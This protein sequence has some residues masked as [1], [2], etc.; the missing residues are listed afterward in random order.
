MP[1]I[2]LVTGGSSDIGCALIRRLLTNGR[3][4]SV[5]AH[6]HSGADRIANLHAQFGE[7]VYPVHADFSDGASVKA[8]ADEIASN[9]G[10]PSQIV[11]LPALRL[12]Y[13]RIA[14]FNLERFRKDMAIQVEALVILLG[15]FAAKMS[16]KPDARMVLVLSSV[17][18]GMPPKFTS[19]YATVKYAQLGLMR[20]AAAEYAATNL[21][22]NAISP[23]MVE[24]KFL[25]DIGET[26]VEMSAA[27]NPRGRNAHPDD[28][29]G[30][31]EFLLSPAAGYITGV[32]IPIAAGS[33]C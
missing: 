15:Y 29:L 26:A 23:G 28:L 9:F 24:T 16:K 19:M 10:A 3:D 21:T 4:L 31:I 5:I 20:A 33:V 32:D 6:S 1:D 7:R 18:H 12:T 13:E 30:A 2:V 11:H 22:V 25:A 27:A 14:K 8:M 17:I